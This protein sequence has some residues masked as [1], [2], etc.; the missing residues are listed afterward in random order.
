[1]TRDRDG[2]C[3]HGTYVGGCGP[4]LMCQWCESGASWSDYVG[5]WVGVHERRAADALNMVRVMLSVGMSTA[6]Q[7][8]MSD[9]D[10]LWTF[11]NDQLHTYN[12]CREAAVRVA[13]EIEP[14]DH[15]GETVQRV[16]H[17][18]LGDAPRGTVQTLCVDCGTELS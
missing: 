2:Y 1:M 6:A 5:Y 10:V 16:A 9:G 3:E 18:Y 13:S 15:S 4:D 8:E 17:G 12:A 11:L 7:L 14:C